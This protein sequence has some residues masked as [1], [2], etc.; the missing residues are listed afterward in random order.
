MLGIKEDGKVHI[1]GRENTSG[2]N[3]RYKLL[4]AAIY[5]RY[6]AACLPSAWAANKDKLWKWENPLP[7]FSTKQGKVSN[8]KLAM[9]P[10]LPL[11]RC[12]VSVRLGVPL[13]QGCG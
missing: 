12:L 13:L 1:K 11:A 5:N 2:G 3:R 7:C 9:P 8:M 10:V 6:R 4:W